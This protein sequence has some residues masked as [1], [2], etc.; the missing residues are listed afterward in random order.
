MEHLSKRSFLLRKLLKITTIGIVAGLGIG[1]VA[2]AATV[3]DGFGPGDSFEAGRVVSWSNQPAN[4]G[5]FPDAMDGDW[6]FGFTPT[7]DYSLDSLEIALSHVTSRGANEAEIILRSG[8]GGSP[9][10]ELERW[11]IVGMDA[12]GSIETFT[13]T[14]MAQLLAGETYWIELSAGTEGSASVAGAGWHSSTGAVSQRQRQYD[15]GSWVSS[16]TFNYAYRVNGTL[17]PVP[18]P[19]GA[20]LL[21]AGLVLLGTLRRRNRKAA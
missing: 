19:A 9:G 6:A 10:A 8:L 2:Q 4:T 12:G 21:P 16:G 17:A 11:S 20:L 5:S 15:E 7:N 3:F 18:L 13:S 1:G 14:T